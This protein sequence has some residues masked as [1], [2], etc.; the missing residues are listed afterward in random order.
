[1][2]T[3]IRSNIIDLNSQYHAILSYLKLKIMRKRRSKKK[4]SNKG[5]KPEI[6]DVGIPRQYHEKLYTAMMTHDP[7]TLP[8]LNAIMIEASE[9]SSCH[10]EDQL[11]KPWQSEEV[12]QLI[13][14]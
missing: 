1:M 3:N 5:W 4:S 7:H 14:K 2:H 12:Q 11:R 10:I 13:L 8:E 6:D 9:K